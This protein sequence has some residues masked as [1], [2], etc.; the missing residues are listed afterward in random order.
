MDA[1]LQISRKVHRM[2]EEDFSELYNFLFQ[3]S[4]APFDKIVEAAFGQNEGRFVPTVS[5]N[6]QQIHPMFGVIAMSMALYKE[7]EAYNMAFKGLIHTARKA[8]EFV[9]ELVPI[10]MIEYVL[11]EEDR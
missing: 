1:V 8:A 3:K 10:E 7:E 2:A 9:A 11:D 4:E 6:I 5:E